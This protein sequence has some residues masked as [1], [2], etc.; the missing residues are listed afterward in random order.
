MLK[1]DGFPLCLSGGL[2]EGDQFFVERLSASSHDV[3][4]LCSHLFRRRV[5]SRQ[6]THAGMPAGALFFVYEAP[7]PPPPPTIKTSC[8]DGLW[9][10]EFECVPLPLFTY[11]SHSFF[12]FV[13]RFRVKFFLLVQVMVVVGEFSKSVRSFIFMWGTKSRKKCSGWYKYTISYEWETLSAVKSPRNLKAEAFIRGPLWPI[14]S[15]TSNL[16]YF[17]PRS[18]GQ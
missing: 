17:Y 16:L 3:S 11:G 10:L 14:K 4:Q 13:I 2:P 6:Q 18:A 15:T 5:W 1:F 12:L 8:F 9:D 7:P